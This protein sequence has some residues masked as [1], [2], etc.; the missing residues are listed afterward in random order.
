MVD[1]P[2]I[3]VKEDQKLLDK[4]LNFSDALNGDLFFGNK[5]HNS[6]MHS[7]SNKLDDF[8]GGCILSSWIELF[9]L[10]KDLKIMG[11]LPKKVEE[12]IY[13]R[14]SCPTMLWW[15]VGRASVGAGHSR[16][17]SSLSGCGWWWSV[18][19]HSRAWFGTITTSR[20]FCS[21]RNY[22]HCKN[23][24][25]WAPRSFTSGYW[26]YY[27]II[28]ALKRQLSM[29]LTRRT[30]AILGLNWGSENY[31]KISMLVGW[32][33]ILLLLFSHNYS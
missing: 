10:G 6:K 32:N 15:T 19:G 31:A 29:I 21:P 25:R 16:K 7:S 12:P 3:I 5:V 20:W 2:P 28:I 22:P 17:Y 13:S 4:Q 26:D 24:A 23:G 33:Y 30:I 11:F 1:E 9:E 14:S 18:S 27:I 8:N